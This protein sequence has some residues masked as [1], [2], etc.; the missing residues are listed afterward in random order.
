LFRRT[1]KRTAGEIIHLAYLTNIYPAPSHSFIRREIL[2]HEAAG[3]RVLR[4]TVRRH[5]G[6]LPEALD[7]AERDRTRC[8][9]EAGALRLA[10]A[11]L[12]AAV[13]RPLRLA[14][15][16]GKA[17]RI[18]RAGRV[19]ILLHLVY[20]AEACLLLRWLRAERVD[21]LHVHFGT[22]PAAVAMFCRMLGGPPWSLTVHGPEEFNRV[23]QLALPEKLKS[24]AFAAAISDFTRSQLY[25]Y[26]PSGLWDRVQV[27]R[28]GLDGLFLDA[29]ALPIPSTQ[30]LVC[31]GRLCQQKGQMLLLQAIAEV[32]RV[33]PSV[34]LTLVGDGPMRRELG[35]EIARLGL[36]KVVSI[37]GYVGAQR[38]R[39]EIES[40]RAMVLPSFAEGLPVVLMEAM[41]L[42]RPVLS[43]YIAG[44]PELIQPG[45]NGWLVPAGSKQR[46]VEALREVL[47]TPR[48]ILSEMGLR[49]RESVRQRHS[50][51]AEALRLSALFAGAAETRKPVAGLPLESSE[52]LPVHRPFLPANR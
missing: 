37:S 22:N 25:R 21:H 47:T 31:V 41:A 27:V 35:A 50:A 15:A 36:E 20:V 45:V 52:S 51:S 30:K 19:S 4:F 7:Q 3:Q 8:I 2:A 11:V 28:C 44:I 38:V 9:L 43:T 23:A 13:T 6:A 26:C 34:Q 5:A 18:S 49:G 40:S 29:D 33:V 46:L 48:E 39:E 1:D 16:M 24:A 42:G 32:R 14:A 17:T 10:L 12:A